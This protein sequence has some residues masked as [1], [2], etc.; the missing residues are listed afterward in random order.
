MATD[1]QRSEIFAVNFAALAREIAMN[2]LP[3]EDILR[4][5]QLSDEE[6]QKIQGD[7]QFQAML[8]GLVKEWESA[9][10]TRERVKIKAATALEAQL[11]VYVSDIADNSIPLAQRVEAGKFLARLG[12]LDG[13]RD[14]GIGERFSI[15][16]NIGSLTREVEVTKT[17][18]A[19]VTAIPEGD[20]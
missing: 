5:H 19:S 6:W 2:I 3:V 14:A 10:N 13:S 15:A 11:E 8:S 17:I 20:E 16:I 18:N 4:L 1:M 9:D 12:Q 7:M